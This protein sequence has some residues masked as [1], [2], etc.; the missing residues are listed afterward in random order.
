MELAT[1]DAARVG[2]RVEW[3][4]TTP[5]GVHSVFALGS[6]K[7]P[8][9]VVA[10]HWAATIVGEDEVWFFDGQIYSRYRGEGDKLSELQSCTDAK[11]EERAPEILKKW[12]ASK[13]PNQ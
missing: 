7:T 1:F 2:Y 12:V 11:V 13:K 8:R 5:N 9:P 3:T 6:T 4:T 10:D